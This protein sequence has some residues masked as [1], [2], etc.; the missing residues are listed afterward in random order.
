MRMTL[1]WFCL[2]LAACAK[3]GIRCDAHLQAINQPAHASSFSG[4]PPS[5]PAPTPVP[6]PLAAG[7]APDDR[8]AP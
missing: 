2:G 1:F 7:A 4:T 8:G 3:H 6:V 5:P